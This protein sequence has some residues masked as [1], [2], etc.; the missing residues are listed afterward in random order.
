MVVC[1]SNGKWLNMA[2]ILVRSPRGAAAKLAE[3]VEQTGLGVSIPDRKSKSPRPGRSAP[4]R[5][6]R[7]I[8]IYSLTAR[9][10]AEAPEVLSRQHSKPSGWRYLL[11][12]GEKCWFVDF[13]I[14]TTGLVVNQIVRGSA[15]ER[16]VAACRFVEE[17]E[18]GLHGELR[19]LRI[20]TRRVS[21]LWIA[22]KEDL[23]VDLD[24]DQPRF[25]DA[26]F[27]AEAKT[28]VFDL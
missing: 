14:G 4:V 1:L 19:V 28:K 16:F 21:A 25:A 11:F 20:P 5:R 27:L 24:A 26:K 6:S 17:Q 9:D 12:Q 18:S 13:R 2:L 3:L 7:A 8:P 15:P 23:F 10:L 22:G